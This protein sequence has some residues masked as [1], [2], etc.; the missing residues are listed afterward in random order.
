MQEIT[1]KNDIEIINFEASVINLKHLIARSTFIK[2][3]FN[4][5]LNST[6]K[7]FIGW[8]KSVSE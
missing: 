8:N 4:F 2:K 7:K 5:L 3:I 1:E 6:H